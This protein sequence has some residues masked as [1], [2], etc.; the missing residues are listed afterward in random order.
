M[1]T[2]TKPT[3]HTPMQNQ[4]KKNNN[5]NNNKNNNNNNI[6]HTSLYSYFANILADMSIALQQPELHQQISL[7]SKAI[8][9]QFM[10]IGDS[11]YVSILGDRSIILR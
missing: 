1:H 9:G 6:Q 3:K 11:Y 5:N 4:K 7:S 8:L 2:Y 10:G